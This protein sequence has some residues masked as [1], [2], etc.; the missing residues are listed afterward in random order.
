MRTFIDPTLPKF[1]DFNETFKGRDSRLTEVVMNSGS[2]FKS[3]G[4]PLNVEPYP[5]LVGE[6]YSERG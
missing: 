1:K 2:K 5:I 6:D 4:K 3:N